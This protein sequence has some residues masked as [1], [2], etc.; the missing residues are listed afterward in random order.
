MGTKKTKRQK[1]YNKKK[2]LSSKSIHSMSAMHTKIY[3][4]GIAIIRISDCHNSIKIWNNI[5]KPGEIKELIRKIDVMVKL[6]SDFKTELISRQRDMYFSNV[7]D[8]VESKHNE[9][10]NPETKQTYGNE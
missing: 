8:K 3:D 2:F 4:D 7:I 1:T 5:N 6:A 10:I 9:P